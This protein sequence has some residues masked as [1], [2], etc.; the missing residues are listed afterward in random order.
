MRLNTE[1]EIE[2]IKKHNESLNKNSIN[3]IG[4]FKKFTTKNIKIV[5]NIKRK[6]EVE[7]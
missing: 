5:Y 2:Y 6:K 3:F 1:E 7:K 4:V